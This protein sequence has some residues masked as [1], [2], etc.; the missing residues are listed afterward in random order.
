MKLQ[1]GLWFALLV[2]LL[3][4]GCTAKEKGPKIVVEDPWARSSPKVAEMGAIYLTLINQGSEPD[5]LVG[6]RTDACRKIEIHETYKKEDGSMGM[7]PVQGGKIA[8]S[9]GEKVQL[10]P[11]GLHIMCIGKQ[12]EFKPGTTF[13]LTLEFEKHEPLTV[14]VEV[15]K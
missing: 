13:Q 9:P 4:L 15:R 6:A 11:G 14:T 8:L 1:K 10:K 7:R 12:I 5:A 3:L 2:V